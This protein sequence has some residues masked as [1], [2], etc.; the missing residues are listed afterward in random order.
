M[1]WNPPRRK[2]T[3]KDQMKA[4]VLISRFGYVRDLEVK[5]GEK[6]LEI[7]KM[8]WIGDGLSSP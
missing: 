4:C 5:Y 3:R 2:A 7:G 1:V 6:Q 8:P